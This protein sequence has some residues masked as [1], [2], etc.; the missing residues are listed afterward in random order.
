MNQELKKDWIAKLRSGD[1][2]QGTCT[3]YSEYAN[4]YCCLGVLAYGC[5]GFNK[6]DDQNEHYNAVEAAIGRSFLVSSRT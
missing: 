1:Y 4:A 3:L 6:T 2:K 5:M